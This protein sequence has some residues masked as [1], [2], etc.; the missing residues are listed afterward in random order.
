MGELP[1]IVVEQKAGPVVDAAIDALRV[2]EVVWER[3]GQLVE[4]LIDDRD[5]PDGHQ[6]TAAHSVAV[7]VHRLA[8]LLDDVADWTKWVK[9]KGED[10]DDFEKVPT[11]P[12]TKIVQMVLDRKRWP[13][14][15]LHGITETPFPRPDGTVMTSRGYDAATGYYCAPGADIAVDVHPEANRDDAEAALA[16]LHDLFS[17]FP[18]ETPAHR[19]CAIAAMLTLVA[20]PAIPGPCPLF[21]FTSST[22]ASGKSLLVDVI[23]EVAVG[24]QPHRTTYP[25]RDDEQE[26][27]ITSILMAGHT[28]VAIDNIDGTFGSAHLDAL[29][30]TTL[31]MG[32]ELGRS[33]MVSVIALT[34]WFATGNNMRIKGD[35]ARRVIPIRLEP[36]VERPEERTAFRHERILDHVRQ[37]RRRYLSAALT[38]L[39]AYRRS[40]APV[41][42]TGFGTFEDWSEVV[43]GPLVWLGE[44]DPVEARRAWAE[45]AD[46]KREA[47]LALAAAWWD[48]MRS[49]AVTLAQLPE[50][51]AV[52]NERS[53]LRDALT[54]LAG[55]GNTI[56][57]R[58]LGN[59]LRRERGRV[60]GRYRWDYAETRSHGARRW[61]LHRLDVAGGAATPG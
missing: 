23:H 40:A 52:G 2:A 35:L 48:V 43:R 44:P 21:A 37:H 18:F 20:R 3:G 14:P 13:I 51:A 57:T 7:T 61:R 55:R 42:M 29:L 30:T 39:T 4:V 46:E 6:S 1:E 60:F 22:P 38:I 26:K 45:D 25:E 17:D 31:W 33:A 53:A 36:G 32:R 15:S 12:P 11:S 9:R 41:Q 34:V 19:S 59:M 47:Y 28:S 16:E 8:E 27:R 5:Q 10:D 58:L 54:A 50:I 56:D 49:D 24:R